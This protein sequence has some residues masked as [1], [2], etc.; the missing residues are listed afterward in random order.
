[1]HPHEREIRLRAAATPFQPFTIVTVSGERYR[2]PHTDHLM[3][4]P[5]TDEDG[6]PLPEEERP[7]AF[8]LATRG[9]HYRI[10]FFDAVS[11]FDELAVMPN[12]Q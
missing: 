11:A 2:V 7:A 8:I 5:L 3:F 9:S 10:V 1:M 4:F 6:T 12:G